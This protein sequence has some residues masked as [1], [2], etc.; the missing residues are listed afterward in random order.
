MKCG[1]RLWVLSTRLLGEFALTT[2]V[3]RVIIRPSRIVTQL[4]ATFTMAED[5][6][7]I[8]PVYE[9]DVWA[10]GCIVVS[11]LSVREAS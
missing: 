5:E 10:D 9:F 1:V 8:L 11:C 3:R 6:F 2:H 7:A 4:R